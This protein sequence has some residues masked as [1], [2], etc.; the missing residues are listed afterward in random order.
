MAANL[1]SSGIEILSSHQV[2]IKKADEEMKGEDSEED[3][4]DELTDDQYEQ[5]EFII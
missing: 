2:Q 3:D 5:L 1:Q 4:D